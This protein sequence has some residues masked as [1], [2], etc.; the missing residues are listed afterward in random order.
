MCPVMT[1]YGMTMSP[2]L[3]SL[4][5]TIAPDTRS[6]SKNN[7]ILRSISVSLILSDVRTFRKAKYTVYGLTIWM[8]LDPAVTVSYQELI[9]SKTWGLTQPISIGMPGVKPWDTK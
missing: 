5:F 8:H 3:I 7:H 2:V 1:T 4:T 6:Q 9:G